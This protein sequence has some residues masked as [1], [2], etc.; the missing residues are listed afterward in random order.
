MNLPLNLSLAK[1]NY[2][3]SWQL[4]RYVKSVVFCFTGLN[5][6]TGDPRLRL[7]GLV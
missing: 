2:S 1:Y 3:V 6:V 4:V 5:V 7:W